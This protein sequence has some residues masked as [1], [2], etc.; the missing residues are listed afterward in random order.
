MKEAVIRVR[1]SGTTISLYEL[2]PG[3]GFG[4]A[5][6]GTPRYTMRS[7]GAPFKIERVEVKRHQEE[8]GGKMV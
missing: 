1:G 8:D 5:A 2:I 7:G 3:R 4:T 6:G